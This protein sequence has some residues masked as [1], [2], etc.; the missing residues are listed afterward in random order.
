M[1]K[2]GASRALPLVICAILLRSQL[3]SSFSAGIVLPGVTKKFSF[4]QSVG[5]L[6]GG[7]NV[8]IY[9]VSMQYRQDNIGLVI[10]PQSEGQGWFDDR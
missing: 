4:S 9:K 5:A 3:S 6:R 10:R 2:M 1:G 7:R 8:A